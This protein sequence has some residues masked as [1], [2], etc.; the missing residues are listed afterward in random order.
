MQDWQDGNE[1]LRNRTCKSLVNVSHVAIA[2]TDHAVLTSISEAAMDD[3]I[4][5]IVSKVLFDKRVVDESH[6]GRHCFSG[7]NFQNRSL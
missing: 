2:H 4:L 6:V 7:S 5:S 3:H 1:R